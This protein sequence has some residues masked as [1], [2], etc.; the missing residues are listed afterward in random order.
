ME[1]IISLK[2]RGYR[3]H[4]II[5]KIVLDVSRKSFINLFLD[6]RSPTKFANFNQKNAGRGT[7]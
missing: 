6:I 2:I 4:E 5:I 1:L 3:D 7:F